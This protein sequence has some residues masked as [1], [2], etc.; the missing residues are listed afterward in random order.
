MSDDVEFVEENEE[1]H[2]QVIMPIKYY[3]D[4]LRDQE[5]LNCLLAA[6][7]DNWEGYT[8]ALEMMEDYND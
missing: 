5:M 6:G 4:L 3:Q 7:V 8:E 2:S 1:D